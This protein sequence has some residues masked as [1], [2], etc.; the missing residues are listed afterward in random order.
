MPQHI[1]EKALA[2]L[3]Q[4]EGLRLNAYLCPGGVLTIGYGH[5]E[6]VRPGMK[7]TA[8]QAED[9]LRHDVTGTEKHVTRLVRVALNENQFGALVCFVFNIGAGAFARSTLLNLLNRGWYA[10]V[11]AQL[12]R[13]CRAGGQESEGLRRRR[14]DEAALWSTPVEETQS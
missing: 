12:L 2:L 3:R 7:I 10:Q 1:N 9:L 8:A 5:T 13:W 6:G 14:H 4:H 11:P